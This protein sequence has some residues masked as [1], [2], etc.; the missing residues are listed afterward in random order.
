MSAL[1][2][3]IDESDDVTTVTMNFFL[4]KRGFKDIIISACYEGFLASEV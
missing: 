4:F 1:I 2:H 3:S